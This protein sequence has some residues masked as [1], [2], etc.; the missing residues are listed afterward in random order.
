[1]ATKSAIAARK[2]QATER[3]KSTFDGLRGQ[4]IDIPD[5]P[6]YSRKPDIAEAEQL[7]YFADAI[8]AIANGCQKPEP[9]EPVKPK[10][11]PK[12]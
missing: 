2:G 7:E 9:K 6:L 5:F 10:P 4:G 8:E 3:I 11:A 1:M 12:K